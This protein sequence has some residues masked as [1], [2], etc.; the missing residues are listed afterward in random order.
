MPFSKLIGACHKLITGP[1]DGDT[2]ALLMCDAIAMRK[3]IAA[4]YQR[5]GKYVDPPSEQTDFTEFGRGDSLETRTHFSILY[6]VFLILYNRL[7]IALGGEESREL[8]KNT[9]KIAT[10]IV[11]SPY[12]NQYAKSQSNMMI[13]WA[14]SHAALGTTEDWSPHLVSPE[15]GALGIRPLIPVDSWKRFLILCGVH[16]VQETVM[17]SRVQAL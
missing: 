12:V 5:W 6:K 14:T 10:F 1:Y 9:S 17:R 11:Q 16:P 13:A 15:D 4:W 8:E 7:Y 3:R 2:H